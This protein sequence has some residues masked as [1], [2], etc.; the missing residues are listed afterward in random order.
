VRE[1]AIEDLLEYLGQEGAFAFSFIFNN[2]RG[3]IG[4]FEDSR[5]GV[6]DDDFMDAEGGQPFGICKSFCAV[7]LPWCSATS[8]A[9]TRSHSYRW[10][11][12]GFSIFPRNFQCRFNTVATSAGILD[13]NKRIFMCVGVSNLLVWTIIC[14]GIMQP[15]RV[16]CESHITEFNRDKFPSRRCSD[17]SYLAGGWCN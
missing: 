15:L 4:D 7:L 17:S 14:L 12:S 5:K 2:R 11:S 3:E 10:K 13:L 16:K 9:Y 1:D 6:M 8:G